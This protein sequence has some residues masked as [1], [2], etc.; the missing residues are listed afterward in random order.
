MKLWRGPVF[1][2]RQGRDSI[3][4]FLFAETD[5]RTPEERPKSQRIAPVG[6]GAG[7]GDQIL[8]LLP[9]EEALA[10]L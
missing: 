10:R 1:P 6:D 9:A 5:K 2:G 4:D 3:S 7:Q 8:N